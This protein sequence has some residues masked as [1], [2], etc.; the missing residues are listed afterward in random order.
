MLFLPHLVFGSITVTTTTNGTQIDGYFNET[1]T[2]SVQ[3]DLDNVTTNDLDTYGSGG[4]YLQ[5]AWAEDG[6]TPSSFSNMSSPST[7]AF[8]SG[9]ATI[10]ATNS[11]LTAT[12]ANPDQDNFD[13]KVVIL[14]AL[15]VPS[16]STSEDVTFEGSNSYIKYDVNDVYTSLGYPGSNFNTFQVQYYLNSEDLSDNLTSTVKFT[17]TSG[18]DNG[19]EHTYTLGSQSSTEKQ[20]GAWRTVTLTDQTTNGNI[21]HDNTYSVNFN[22]R[23]AAGNTW[24]GTYTSKYY[25]TEVPTITGVST[26]KDNG[27]YGIGED[28]PFTVSFSE[29]VT[30]T[31]SM[32]ITFETGTTDQTV[33]ITSGNISSATSVSST[34]TVQEGD[35]S[36]DLSVKSIEMLSGVL[37]DAA[38][39]DMSDFSIPAGQ[40]IDDAKAIVIEGVRPT[41]GSVT[42]S[43]VNGSYSAGEE[44]NVTVNFVNGDGGSAEAVTLTSGENLI[45]TLETGTTDRTVTI[46]AVDISSAST[47]SGTY[48][49][50]SGD[51]S[52]DLEVQQISVSGG[53]LA[54][55]AGNALTSF[56]IPAGQ[57]ID[58]L[59]DIVIETTAPT[60]GSVTSI[61]ADGSYG[62]DSEI[63]VTVNF[64]N[65][66][67]GGAEDVTLNGGDLVITLETG[68]TDRTVTISSIS[69]S[70][71]A[72]GTYTVQEGDV[73]S[74]LSVS[75]IA[76]TGGATLK[77]AAGNS[78]S[79]FDIPPGQ[80]INNSSDIIVEAT[81]PTISSV[82]S[83]T[84]DAT[85][86]I[87]DNINI[88]ITFSEAVTLAGGNLEV[89]LETGDNDRTV[90]I[91]P[92]SN[93]TTA[94][95]T[96]TVQENDTSADLSVNSISLGAG[97]TLKDVVTNNPNAVSDYSI[98][99][100][101]NLDD[102][103]AIVVDG[104]IP[105]ISSVTT[106]T[107]DDY[108]NIDD[109]IN[110]TVNFSEAVT[111][112]GGN[113]LI[114]LETGTTDRQ[115][116]I[117]TISSA[118]S[119][120]GTYTVQSGD[121]S[122]DLS[123]SLIEL[124]GGSL[125]DAAGN[126]MDG[127]GIVGQNLDDAHGIIVD[128]IIPSAPTISSVSATG[129]TEQEDYWNSTNTSTDVTVS[130]PDDDSIIDG[131]VIVQALIGSNNWSNIGQTSTNHENA[132]N[133][134]HELDGEIIV[135]IPVAEGD[136]YDDIEGLAGF[137]DGVEITFKAILT[138][139]AGNSITGNEST[140]SLLVDTTL[141][142]VDNVAST[143]E[144]LKKIGDDIF[145]T[146]TF[147]E[148]VTLAGGNLV[149]DIDASD[150]D[151]IVSSITNSSTVELTYTVAEGDASDTLNV[152]GISTTGT[153][154]DVA[155]NPTTNFDVPDGSNIGDDR[156]IEIDGIYPS[157][158]GITTVTAVGN[159]VVPGYWNEDNTNLDVTVA[160]QSI[161]NSLIGGSIQLKGKI[162][163]AGSFTS[164]GSAYT[165]QFGDINAGSY[166]YRATEAEFD[167]ITN[168]ADGNRIN[169]TATVSDEAGNSRQYTAWDSTVVIDLTDPAEFTVGIVTTTG[170]FEQTG[171][172]NSTNT[173]LEAEIEV[174]SDNT[175][176]GGSVTL[177]GKVDANDFSTASTSDDIT[178]GELG[179]T[180]TVST[181]SSQVK[182]LPSFNNGGV[183]T[184]SAIMIDIAGN[185]TEGNESTSTLVIDTTAATI[186][187]L[188]SSKLEGTYGIGAEIDITV[189]F[190]S[191]VTLN[192]GNV[193][194]YL[195][196]G[197][198]VS[199]GTFSGV[200]EITGTYTVAEGDEAAALSVDSIAVTGGG[201]LRDVAGNPTTDFSIPA[202]QDI[203]DDVS[204]TIDGIYPTADQIGSVTTVGDPTNVGYW[205]SNNTAVKVAVPLDND[206]SLVN[207]TIQL[208]GQVG[209][210]GS[211]DNF[212]ILSTITD[213]NTVDTIIVLATDFETD[214]GFAD[215]DTVYFAAVVTDFAGN[216][217]VFSASDT[218]LIVDQTAPGAFTVGEVVATGPTVVDRY[219][220]S[221]NDGTNITVPIDGLDGSLLGGL[222]V[223]Q[224]RIGVND[225]R[226]IGDISSNMEYG[227][228]TLAEDRQINVPINAST[229]NIDS[230]EGLVDDAVIEVRAK[231]Q[232]VAGN[233]IFGAM[234]DST[235]TVDETDPTVSK[236]TSP[237]PN[238]YYNANDTILVHVITDEQVSVSGLPEPILS[239]DTDTSGVGDNNAEYISGSGSDTLVFE[240]VVLAGD[241]TGDLDYNG[242]DALS[243][244]GSTIID[245]A[246]NDLNT[247]LP[248][249]GA[250]ESLA[251]NKFI[252]LD[253][254]APACALSYFPDSLVGIGD[255][256]VLITATMTDFFTPTPT[257]SIDL[258]E[259]TDDISSTTMT[260]T[261]N[262]LV[263]TY[264][265]DLPDTVNGIITVTV[266]GNDKAGNVLFLPDSLTGDTALRIDTQIPVFSQITPD[267]GA[268]VNFTEVAYIITEHAD[269]PGRLF[270]GT[271]TWM[272][273]DI[274]A[275]LVPSELDTGD[276]SLDTLSADPQ[277]VDGVLYTLTI[278]SQDSAGNSGSTIVNSVT[279][280][281]TPP[282]ALLTYSSYLTRADSTVTITATF[283]EPAL[284]TPQITIDYADVF[285]DG[286]IDMIPV[287]GSDSTEW[288]YGATIPEGNDGIATVTID[289]TDLAANSL[290]TDSTF[291]RDTLL[292]D[293][294]SPS[295]FSTT[296]TD[297][298]V[299][300]LD[301]DSVTVVFSEAMRP[302][303]MLEV[304]WAGGD[305]LESSPMTEVNGTDSTEWIFVISSIPDSND[306]FATV[307]IEAL[308]DA[309]NPITSSSS[310]IIEV[311][312]EHPT[313][314]SVEPD[315]NSFVND[316]EIAY[317][318]SEELESGTVTWQWISGV[319]D[320]V[321]HIDTL[322]G[323]ELL[324]GVHDPFEPVNAPDLTDGS[325]YRATFD[326]FDFAGNAA[327]QTISDSV[328]YDTT[329]PIVDSL[330]YS[331]NPAMPGDTVEVRAYF[332]E[333]VPTTPSIVTTWP[334]QGGTVQI[335]LDSTL[336]GEMLVWLS[337]VVIVNTNITSSGTV[338][339]IPTGQD[340]AENQIDSV[341]GMTMILD[342]TWYIDVDAP[343]CSLTYTNISQPTLT[344]LGKG[345]D[346]VQITATF[347]EK[348]SGLDEVRPGL[349]I[350][351][352]DTSN[353]SIE[354]TL[355]T[356]S[357]N[358]DTTWTFSFDL[359]SD[360]SSTGFMTVRLSAYDL[361]GNLVEDV[362]DTNVFEIDNIPPAPFATGTVTPMGRQPKEGWFNE[363]TDS[364]SVTAPMDSEDESLPDGKMQVRM[365]IQGTLDSVNV[366]TPSTISNISIP[367]TINLM[368]NTIRAAFIPEDF[369]EG[370]LILTW[371]E[372]YD[373]AGNVS[374]GSVS[375]DTLVVDTIPPNSLLAQ[376][377][378]DGLAADDSVNI[379]SSD[380][381]S[382]AWTGFADDVPPGES[383][384]EQYEWAV[385]Y[386]DSVALHQVMN[387]TS[388]VDL[389]TF[390]S[391]QLQLTHNTSYRASIRATDFAGNLSDTLQS[392]KITRFNSAP[393]LVVV[394]DTSVDEDVQFLYTITAT[395]VDTATLE[396]EILSYF[397]DTMYVVPDTGFKYS[398]DLD[399]S[400]GE[401]DWNTPLQADTGSYT[402]EIVVI[403]KDS[404]S[405]TTMFVL[406][407]NSVNDTP[408][409]SLIPDIT[410]AEDDIN[411]DTLSLH[412][413][414]VDVDNDTTEL[415]WI[416][417]VMPDSANYPSYPNFFFGPGS[418]P[419]LE[420]IIRRWV[421]T[422]RI[423][424]EFTVFGKKGS[425]SRSGGDTTL[426]VN[427]DTVNGSAFAYFVADSNYY[428]DGREVIFVAADPLG[429]ADST[430]ITVTITPLN[431][432]PVL[433]FMPDTLMAENDTLTLA[434][435]AVDI[436]DSVVTFQV[437]PD[438]SAMVVSL[439]DTFATFIPDQFWVDSTVVLVIVSDEEL[440]DSTQ[441]KLRVLRVPRPSMAL[442]IG[443]NATFTRY[444]EFIVTD[445]AEKA[446]DLSLTIQQT[447]VQVALDT[448]GD[449]TWVG[450]HSFDTTMTYNFVMYGN[451]KVGDTT[452]TRTSELAL[453][454]A[455]AGWIASSAD[456]KFQ[457]IS[458]A[459]AVSY[460]QPFMIVDSLLFPVHENLGGL[461]RIG[462]PLLSFDKPVM[463]TL[464][465]DTALAEDDQALY[466]R[467]EEE[468]WQELPSISQNG[469]LMA[470][471]SKMG[472]FKIGRKTIFVPEHTSIKQNYPNPFN[473][474]THIIYDIGFFGGPDQKINFVIYNLL[475][476]EVYRIA[477]GRAEI[478]RHE[479][480]WNGTDKFGVPVSSGIYISRLTTNAGFS[481]SKK[482]MLMK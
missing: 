153:I 365:V 117:T 246:G 204:L 308:D 158:Q 175:L 373:L 225:W 131:N 180:K 323:T 368:K 304:L 140:V 361:A 463:I 139:V 8:S 216:G 318:L 37:E 320:P 476:Q 41:I 27:T 96:Y 353:H 79:D 22:L 242:T 68:T 482:M 238:G 143:A 29:A 58:D 461:Y 222:V 256:D 82:S 441:F 455:N 157:D 14:D 355:F 220:N 370:R 142:T 456:G 392:A 479:F 51:E 249:T 103:S 76:L 468:I 151:I 60:I 410:F 193:V 418:T 28:I 278:S 107:G 275:D 210:N 241:N 169:I 106:T 407:V 321:T 207:G 412:Q 273:G 313:F 382:A 333:I 406:T 452:V 309:G 467:S 89:L 176:S 359:P 298:L 415:T 403:D 429:L 21:I 360:S 127:F 215:G 400:T 99:A 248:E 190:S 477:K 317:N 431:D 235:L 349:T 233:F 122:S 331:K 251:G 270:S 284:P 50:Q 316:K 343:T 285:I 129:G 450:H 24:S 9:S 88:T 327:I 156:V 295:V 112:S 124:S 454:R 141:A 195:N 401:I 92:F 212:G 371:A 187:E 66:S 31:G 417:V 385:G 162:E 481:A 411:G 93:S 325:V 16:S 65:G 201:T 33:T 398:V 67:G 315:S 445:T 339:V 165:I 115:V 253:T 347:N 40:N 306:G 358:E 404:L 43:S 290:S 94:A 334:E 449:F 167:D 250:D 330:V 111:L 87:S 263:F 232:D 102:A 197:S 49:V 352:P 258:P 473:S 234:S 75:S 384:I 119:A 218:T 247:T 338:D 160:L 388:S 346:E 32:Q 164:F 395:D 170:G 457:I 206:A 229:V 217:Q 163:S 5:I 10:T 57:N 426:A 2:I 470:W 421:L 184:I 200:D 132:I 108:Y 136:G 20:T 301:V 134:S 47:V 128:G 423:K 335:F 152:D 362:V 159:P 30:A 19:T 90:T 38:S 78:L 464:P 35:V 95:G 125:S 224:A 237:T 154:K 314:A 147:T 34:Y 12:N 341:A 178:G 369:A 350:V 393:I 219:W 287:T 135:Q 439:N 430:N 300:E 83:T 223:P 173:G 245:V 390:A 45:I 123:V 53:N 378:S 138:D 322:E 276:H 345:G 354:D 397:L 402:L 3:V 380:S 64:V 459:G 282:S 203:E 116:T 375:T 329:G 52:S 303:P 182:A 427:I 328:M 11:H 437:L 7:V 266:E 13:L 259:T 114:T 280:D 208:T 465:G 425:Y 42:S 196:S 396:G 39:N 80:N 326:G 257:I 420:R 458:G 244:Q 145:I 146:V 389:D 432:P 188:T 409:V 130:L 440:S 413:Y 302:S 23:D 239:L 4:I 126:S 447:G 434:L 44:I 194:V 336:N 91:S 228:V 185:S 46:P 148:N 81:R 84:A 73:S 236:V 179:T 189:R 191:T 363:K 252:V 86:N 357:L 462:H 451:A 444:F 183:I 171:Y 289:A 56:N 254:Y 85:Y 394:P 386:F 211:V 77:D 100:G 448:V 414:V 177:L 283:S 469:M 166:I 446:L 265:L 202:G 408:Q 198:S 453:A 61:T 443:Q 268:F 391:V 221:T 121:V 297:S 472:Y 471:T 62:I 55:A 240:Y 172:W 364:V 324:A 399:S 192:A 168:W 155:G 72:S 279:Y 261:G 71:S 260:P 214:L 17:G 288:N 101:Q 274:Q 416:A 292:V 480:I 133:D 419:K 319:I 272:P 26:T 435:R 466:I 311:D 110:I 286:P 267:T 105:T 15:P 387:W 226:D 97:A 281:I 474:Q 438:T 48:T 351:F 381:I 312:N 231:L 348:A 379:V 120:S 433:A 174:P 137:D 74:D 291:F 442:S 227:I 367:K 186:S 340:R 230:L 383:G 199:F 161:D 243:I 277:L 366:G 372:L 264:S 109:D 310:D 475:G 262:D 344:N 181:D 118:S 269:N 436:D 59:K 205:N 113:L 1:N 294:T 63:N 377:T 307:V 478:G 405:D 332:N 337:D 150:T 296:S 460:D 271:F 374:V 144:G 424:K 305:T 299:K 376:L 213:V 18:S 255:N 104:I 293:N 149:V 356:T 6:S 209:V 70:N 428:V 342:T 25:D 422:K 36:G 69:S 98:P 54:D